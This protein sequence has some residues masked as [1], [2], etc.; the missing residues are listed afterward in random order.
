M[1]ARPLSRFPLIYRGFASHANSTLSPL[2]PAVL[3]LKSGQSFAGKAFGAPRSI[4][5]ET[6]FSTSITSY[7]ESMTDPSYRGQI[8]VF[9][10]PLIGNY[11]VPINKA[12]MDNRDVGVVLESSGIQCA[13][14]VVADL[15]EK[16][17]HYTAIESLASWCT[18][19]NVP[20]ITGVDT[21][22]ITTLLRDQGTTLGRLAVG[23]D[24]SLPA[25]ASHEYWD[26]SAEN[27]VDQISTKEPY[28]L[29]PTGD[30]KIAV[31][32]FGAKANI[33]RSLVRRGASVTVLPWNFDFN[34]VR[35]Q[36]DGLFLSNGPGDPQQ[37]W[38]AAHKLRQ[39]LAEWDKPVF[40]ICMG[41]Q[42]I[43]MAAGLE[44][45]RMTFGNRGHNQPVLA[46]ASS[47]SIK[48]GRV[49]VTSQNHQYALKLQDPF[50]QGWEPFFINANDSS[51][52]GIKS[53]AESG[54]RIWGVQFHPESAGG[55][56]DTIEVGLV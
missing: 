1:F 26:P 43:G 32:D 29:N 39:T 14:V 41:H 31:L 53:T 33:L 30:V 55:P 12:P 17:S 42:I 28:E 2:L 51:V 18:R 54:K 3:H 4:Y 24:V 13:G 8:L 46:L 34:A 23:E 38:D 27:L 35:D 19:Y 10:T 20:G 52:E 5:G 48:A 56:L 49:Y 15:A 47:G 36:F 37:C 50:P 25:P 7:T 44:A 22:A 21:R 6:V 16:F 11:G 45:Y 40:G 9:T